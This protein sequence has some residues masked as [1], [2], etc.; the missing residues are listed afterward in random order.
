MRR[1]KPFASFVPVLA[2]L[3]SG[4]V[5]AAQER[6]PVRVPEGN[7]KPILIDG[8]FSPEEWDDAL[9]IDIR[10]NLQ[11]LLKKSAGYVFLGF[12]YIPF[13]LSVIDLFISPDGKS[14]RHLHVSAQLGER[15][16]NDTPGAEDDPEFVW[17]DTAGWYANEIRWNEGKVQALMK[18]GKSPGEA[19]VAS[20][21]KYDGF[22]LQIRQD[23]FGSDEWLVRL[24]TPMAPDW[25]KPVVYPEGTGNASTRG[26]LKLI[27]K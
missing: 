7:G 5:L 11:L 8:L 22:E 6:P 16:L 14:I 19:Q 1:N 10:P 21:Y 9:K 17:G 20:L 18:E 27:F 23:K 25:E 15:L 13:T 4:V 26:W 12:R 3:L 2:L 24:E